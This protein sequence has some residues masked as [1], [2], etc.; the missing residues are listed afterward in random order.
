M[1]DAV[2]FFVA[3]EKYFKSGTKVKTCVQAY[4]LHPGM[5]TYRYKH[6]W[7]ALFRCVAGL[8]RKQ[9]WWCLITGAPTEVGFGPT[10]AILPPAFN[11]HLQVAIM[12]WNAR[13][14]KCTELSIDRF[15]ALA[16][17][18]PRFRGEGPVDHGYYQH[19]ASI[20]DLE[21]SARNGCDL[22]Q[23]FLSHLEGLRWVTGGSRPYYDP[24]L[25]EGPSDSVYDSVKRH[26]ASDVRI[27]I[28]A[29]RQETPSLADVDVFDCIRVQFGPSEPLGSVWHGWNYTQLL[30]CIEERLGSVALSQKALFARR[31]TNRSSR[32]PI[33]CKG[34]SSRETNDRSFLGVTEELQ[35]C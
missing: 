31:R 9:Q 30:I 34:I 14:E 18:H 25:L 24:D 32:C 16:E 11:R 3:R 12:E 7:D 35:D 4:R 21:Q 17:E 22:C 5:W 8:D 10:R 13:C 27:A 15:L 33:L 6:P 19:H 26:N 29:L 28:G 2:N 1:S 20:T 23:Y